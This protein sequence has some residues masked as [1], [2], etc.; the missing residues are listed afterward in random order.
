MGLEPTLL[1]CDHSR[2]IINWQ[3]NSVSFRFVPYVLVSFDTQIIHLSQCSAKS[4]LCQAPIP[5]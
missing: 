4:A 1:Q 3:W 5:L 2:G